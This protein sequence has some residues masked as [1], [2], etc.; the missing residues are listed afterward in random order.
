MLRS[1]TVRISWTPAPSPPT[2][3]PDAKVRRRANYR[4]LATT[5]QHEY[6]E[7]YLPA[8]MLVG[9]GGHGG[10]F[11]RESSRALRCAPQDTDAMRHGCTSRLPQRK[12]T[13]SKF[14]ILPTR[15]HHHNPSIFVSPFRHPTHFFL[16]ACSTLGTVTGM[17]SSAVS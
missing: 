17:F 5:K 4:S 1:F 2:P 12:P 11:L 16:E 14:S 6:Q 3:K 15:G 7:A 8:T 13:F 9:G 10:E